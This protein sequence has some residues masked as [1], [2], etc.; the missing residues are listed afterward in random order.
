MTQ[1]HDQL[2]RGLATNMLD[3]VWGEEFINLNSEQQKAVVDDF[4]TGSENDSTLTANEYQNRIYVGN[5]EAY[6]RCLL[7]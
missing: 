5:L 2:V 7:V 3:R 6:A 4:I 1:I